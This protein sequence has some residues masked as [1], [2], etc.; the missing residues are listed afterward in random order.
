M[1][2]IA[3]LA[4]RESKYQELRNENELLRASVNYDTP[5][6]IAIRTAPISIVISEAGRSDLANWD[7]SDQSPWRL[8]V[9]SAGQ[10]HL[11]TSTDRSF[12]ISKE[13]L[14]ELREL[15]IQQ[16]FFELRDVYGKPE[17]HGELRTISI[18][19]GHWTKTVRLLEFVDES[20]S[21][22]GYLKEP[23]RAL[24]VR[25][26]IRGWFDHLNAVDLRKFDQAIIDLVDEN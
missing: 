23:A 8:S 2:M 18:T 4:W 13:Q 17:L 12:Q 5:S 16:R 19:V 14:N 9:N 6:E 22:L 15:L 11:V 21:Y 7:A 1:G 20:R 10:A 24:R 26:L 25:M 3:N